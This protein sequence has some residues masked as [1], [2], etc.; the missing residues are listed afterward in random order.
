MLLISS[1]VIS[2]ILES[3]GVRGFSF[4]HVQAMVLCLCVM[5]GATLLLDGGFRM[6]VNTAA[7]GVITT[8]IG[9]ALISA[10]LLLRFSDVGIA[11]VALLS[12]AL[13][14]YP[15]TG[16][17]MIGCARPEE[18][19]ESAFEIPRWINWLAVL[20]VGFGWIQFTVKDSI[21][22]LTN[23]DNVSR[24]VEASTLGTFRPPSIFESSFQYGLFSLLVSCVASANGI[25]GRR[26]VLSWTVAVIGA[27]GVVLSQTRN[28]LLC[29]ACAVV[30]MV[31][32]KRAR[33]RG[34]RFRLLR[35]APFAY[36]MSAV[37]VM[38]YAVVRFLGS[39]LEKSGDLADASSTWARVS[40]WQRAWETLVLP[41]SLL[42]WLF[43]FGITQAGQASQFRNL[44][45]TRGEGLF[46]DSTFI[47]LFLLQGLLGLG[48]F[49]L[50]WWIL[51]NQLLKK[52]QEHWDPLTSGVAVFY[53]VFLAAGVFNIL[54]GQWWGILLCLTLLTLSR[55]RA[56]EMCT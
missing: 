55:P 6:T 8:Y 23:N 1:N 22:K 12:H 10:V 4:Y 18:E 15:A 14:F 26:R 39:G 35:I 31:L 3:V 49:L 28:V 27:S 13:L 11:Y 41:G 56:E 54:N 21:L 45:P 29:G 37:G 52:V 25:F 42:D 9:Y 19:Y 16:L 48:L 34:G 30:S 40:S 53:S 44:Y 51:W 2:A 20:I 5:Q 7:W 50:M 38:T 46:I 17:L 43:G 24:L 47:N 32:I 36:L 33:G